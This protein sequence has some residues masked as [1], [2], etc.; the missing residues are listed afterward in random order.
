MTKEAPRWKQRLLSY[1]KA[2][3]QL[4]SALVLNKERELSELEQQGLIKAFEFTYEMA[5]KTLQD[6]LRFDGHLDI[7]GSRST[8][9]RAFKEGLVDNGECW[10]DMVESRNRTSHTYDQAQ[11]EEIIKL[12]VDKYHS[13][14]VKLGS[15]LNN[16]IDDDN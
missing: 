10:L 8:L 12:I 2:L 5:W 9:R 11:A 4:N 16:L 6:Y 7:G 3:N 1:N 13:E 15:K 14:L